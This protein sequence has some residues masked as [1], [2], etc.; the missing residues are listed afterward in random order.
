M[1]K[2]ENSVIKIPKNGNIKISSTS[3]IRKI[4]LTKKNCREKFIRL[5]NLGLKP[6]SNGLNFSLSRRVLQDKR[7]IAV[8]SSKVSKNLRI[9]IKTNIIII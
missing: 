3:K 1:L 9:T 5:F 6:H 8:I 2:R 7:E 4:S